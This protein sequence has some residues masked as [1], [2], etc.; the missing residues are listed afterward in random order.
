MGQPLRTASGT[1]IPYHAA[2]RVSIP[3]HTCASD[4]MHTVRRSLYGH[5][6]TDLESTYLLYTLQGHALDRSS[7]RGVR[8]MN[9]NIPTIYLV[10]SNK[11]DGRLLSRSVT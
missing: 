2:E 8:C 9:N 7:A 4:Y 11:K 6:S 1:A 10:A 3:F 5:T